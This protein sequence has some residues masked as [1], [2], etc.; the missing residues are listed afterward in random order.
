MSIPNGVKAYFRVPFVMIVW[1]METYTKN[2]AQ[3]KTFLAKPRVALAFKVALALTAVA[4]LSVALMANQK[5]GERLTDAVKG[6]VNDAQSLN[7]QKKQMNL[8]KERPPGGAAQ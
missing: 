6:I 1:V 3:F 2:R 4:W 8:Q 5:D 7:D